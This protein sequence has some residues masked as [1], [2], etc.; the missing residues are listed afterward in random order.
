MQFF[1][2]QMLFGCLFMNSQQDPIEQ[3]TDFIIGFYLEEYDK[4]QALYLAANFFP[5]KSV[6][7][8]KDQSTS[9]N[10][11]KMQI[12]LSLNIQLKIDKAF[13]TLSNC[14]LFYLLQV[15][16][17][18]QFYSN[19]L[20]ALVKN[21][22]QSPWKYIPEISVILNQNKPK[23][24]SYTFTIHPKIPALSK[25]SFSLQLKLFQRVSII[26]DLPEQCGPQRRTLQS[27]PP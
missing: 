2:S 3:K 21:F 5:S 19:L 6:I 17:I 25:Y 24:W 10:V 11:P 14:S 15:K 4:Y 23:F 8:N 1:S 18:Y 20:A 9:L 22:I 27:V 13:F 16:I 26:E 7:C 12:N